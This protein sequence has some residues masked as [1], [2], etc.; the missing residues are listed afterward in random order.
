ML[1]HSRGIH[2][3]S[4]AS[5]SSEFVLIDMVVISGRETLILLRLSWNL[6]VSGVYVNDMIYTRLSLTLVFVALVMLK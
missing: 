4:S 3:F 6:H 1:T 2:F 5:H